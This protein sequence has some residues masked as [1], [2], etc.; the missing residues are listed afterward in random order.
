M[1]CHECQ[2]QT[3]HEPAAARRDFPLPLVPVGISGQVPGMALDWLVFAGQVPLNGQVPEHGTNPMSPYSINRPA[4]IAERLR[5]EVVLTDLSSR[6]INLPADAV[7]REI[8][9]AQR[10]LCEALDLD[11]IVLWQLADEPAAGCAATHCHFARQHPPPTGSLDDGDYPWFKQQLLAGRAAGFAALEELPA[12][13]ARDRNAFRRLGIR[14]NLSLPLAVADAPLIGALCL[15]VMR[16]KRAWP[17]ALVQRLQLVAQIFTNA[18]A[19]KRADQAL[20][21]REARLQAGADLAGI[22]CYEIDYA[23]TTTFGDQ[24]FGAICGVPPGQQPD[25]QRMH[26]WIDHVHPDDRPQVLEERQ[27]VYEGQIERYNVEY[28]YLHPTEGLKWLHHQSHVA[29]RDTGGRVVRIYGVVRDIT[30]RKRLSEQLHSAADEWQTTFDAISDLILILDADDRILRV[31]AATALFLG[32]SMDRILGSRCCSLMH[33][34][35]RPLAR[36]PC[37]QTLA[38][39]QRAQLEVFHADPDRWLLFST[40]PIKD[41]AGNLCGAVHVGRDITE[42]KRA[43]AELHQQQRELA[44]IARVNTLGILSGSLAHELNQPLG[45]I[46]SNA[47]AA[48][49]LLTQEPPDMAEVQAI[50]ADIVAADRRAGEVIVRLR[51]LLKRGEATLQ[52]LS[53]NALVEE[54]LHLSRADLIARNV[55]VDLELAAELP[56]VEGDPVQLQQLVLNL[57]LNAAEAMAANAP[58][59]RHLRLRSGLHQGWPRVSVQDEG[60]G[61]PADPERLFESF[62]T[63][64]PQGL[65]MGLSICRSIVTAHHGRL[66][67][68]PNPARGAIFHFELPAAGSLD[69][70]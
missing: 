32:L 11:Q 59:A 20:R 16:T 12:V 70:P 56:A 37:Q 57:I 60:A 21:A 6:F 45:I 51:G 35:L 29:A 4:E 48:Q 15:N 3:G 65:G 44:H 40:H 36:C 28:R 55:T 10:S 43:A 26:F 69:T 2:F 58:G 17:E 39:G 23:Q 67:A 1:N 64:K 66:W 46:L 24:R 25:L 49:E 38:T 19:R 30:Q 61:L 53:L 27:K 50:L 68:E 33:G 31:N 34:H 62:H 5:V 41:A 13:A 52:A 8:V 22:G 14:S 54:V 18:L 47:Q 7:D 9:A 42:T 63:T